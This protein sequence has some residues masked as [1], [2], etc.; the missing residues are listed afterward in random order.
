MEPLY[1]PI[2]LPLYPNAN[3]KHDPY[4]YPNPS[5]NPTPYSYPLLPFRPSRCFFFFSCGI[6]A[7]FITASEDAET[8]CYKVGR[9]SGGSGLHPY[10]NLSTLT[11]SRGNEAETR[12]KAGRDGLA[13]NDFLKVLVSD[14]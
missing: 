13:I 2:P 6:F 1:P 5:F 8:A 12:K 7:H 14:V 10:V 4:A 11:I 9:G 3:P